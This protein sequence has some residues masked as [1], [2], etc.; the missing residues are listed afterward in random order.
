M[1][2]NHIIVE[3][4]ERSEI[5]K[6]DDHQT[7]SVNDPVNLLNDPDSNN[8][9]MEAICQPVSERVCE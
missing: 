4:R 8:D 5:Y 7:L 1:K 3:S 2:K 6:P 9:P